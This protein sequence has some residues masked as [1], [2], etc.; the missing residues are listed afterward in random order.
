M[1]GGID[2]LRAA[3]EELE[4][5]LARQEAADESSQETNEDEDDSAGAAVDVS[6]SVTQAQEFL[7]LA[8]SV[9][10]AGGRAPQCCFFICVWWMVIHLRT[11]LPRCVSGA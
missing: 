6:S 3:V 10:V 5:K 8:K 9:K 4:A 2:P 7:N 1:Q 11:S